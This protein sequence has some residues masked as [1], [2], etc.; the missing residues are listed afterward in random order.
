MDEPPGKYLVGYGKPPAAHR[1]RKGQSGNPSGRPKGSKGKKVDTGFG[2]KPAEEFLRIAVCPGYCDRTG[3][4]P[5]KRLR[6]L[7]AAKEI[8]ERNL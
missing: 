7:S 2:M 6:L 5:S 3:R 1:F 4:A 8:I